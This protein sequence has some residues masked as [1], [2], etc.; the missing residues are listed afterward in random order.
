MP[1]H[2]HL[3]IWPTPSQ[4]KVGP[5]LST[6]K[7]S[8]SKRALKWAR[9]HAPAFLEHLADVA[10]DGSV[11]HRFWQRGAG[12]D[13]NLWSPIHIWETIDYIHTNP[14]H[15]GL[16]GSPEEWE[17]SSARAYQDLDA[18]P[19]PI[20]RDHM[21]PKPVLF[22]AVVFVGIRLSAT[23]KRARTHSHEDVAMCWRTDL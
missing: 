21:P 2:V 22:S 15:R 11:T 17:W 1:E 10:P 13:R 5:I 16:C 7:Q 19:L 9:D 12:Y 3:L 6:I 18:G 20:D 4:S 23:D 14:V 8:V